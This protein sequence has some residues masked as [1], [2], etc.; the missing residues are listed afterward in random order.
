MTEL[1]GDGPVGTDAFARVTA[2]LR[3]SGYLALI[4]QGAPTLDRPMAAA[5]PCASRGSC[6]S[7]DRRGFSTRLKATTPTVQNAS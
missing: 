5:V 3:G 4:E 2:T 7:W 6:G 1:F